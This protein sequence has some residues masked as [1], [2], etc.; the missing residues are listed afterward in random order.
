LLI[1]ALPQCFSKVVERVRFS[2][3]VNR[4]ERPLG[5]TLDS[6]FRGNDRF[7]HAREGGHPGQHRRP[8]KT[9]MHPKEKGAV[10]SF[11]WFYP[12]GGFFVVAASPH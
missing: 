11:A 5:V 9:E 12:A 8:L 4:T 6:R 10:Q 1:V 7:R 2:Y 3:W